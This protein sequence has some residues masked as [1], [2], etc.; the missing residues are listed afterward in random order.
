MLLCFVFLSFFFLM[1]RRPPRSTLFPYTT[2]FRSA[3]PVTLTTT[4]HRPGHV[5]CED[6]ARSASRT[7]PRR[8]H[9]PAPPAQARPGTHST[10]ALLVT[11]PYQ[12]VGASVVPDAVHEPG[13]TG[14]A[15]RPPRVQAGQAHLVERRVD[16]KAREAHRT[17]RGRQPS[18]DDDLRKDNRGR[19]PLHRRHPDGPPPRTPPQTPPSIRR[20]RRM[21]WLGRSHLWCLSTEASAWQ[22]RRLYRIL[23][24]ERRW[25]LQPDCRVTPRTHHRLAAD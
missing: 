15:T 22:S 5:P 4:S 19:E 11:W 10:L 21:P 18:R 23:H 9:R 6:C 16:A 1:I 14:T 24:P 7:G 12:A 25:N 13:P 8:R 2:L 3:P 17:G 20:P